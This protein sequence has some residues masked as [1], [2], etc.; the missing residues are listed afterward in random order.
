[1]EQMG[2]GNLGRANGAHVP[3]ASVGY[4]A[5]GF[6]YCQRDTYQA[7]L[8]TAGLPEGSGSRRSEGVQF[9]PSPNLNDGA[10][11][12]AKIATYH[13]FLEANERMAAEY[14]ERQP[15]RVRRAILEHG[16]D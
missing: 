10:E 7:F 6:A 1:M 3:S 16:L 5:G 9:P 13:K 12:E 15:E 4:M 11:L 2:G 8:K 14:L